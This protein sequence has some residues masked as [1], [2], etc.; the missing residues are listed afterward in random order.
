MN[1]LYICT[2]FLLVSA[3]AVVSPPTGGPVDTEPPVLLKVIP[4]HNSVNVQQSIF[5]FTFNEFFTLKKPERYI[6]IS[7]LLPDNK[8]EHRIQG[9]SLFLK[10]AQPLSHPTTYFFILDSLIADF[11]EGNILSTFRYVISSSSTIDSLRL[12]GVIVSAKGDALPGGIFLYLFPAEN[13]TVLLT[14]QFC[15]VTKKGQQGEF[16]FDHIPPGQYFLMA[17]Q[18]IDGNHLYSRLDEMVGFLKDPVNVR[19]HQINDTTWTRETR[20]NEPLR[21][22]RVPD[23]ALYVRKIDKVRKGLF[24]IAFSL[25]VD[26]VSISFAEPSNVQA[27]I[28][29]L[30]DR[31]DTC[32][33]WIRQ[34]KTSPLKFVI[35]ANGKTLDT[36]T[37]VPKSSERLGGTTETYQQLK[38]N[39]FGVINDSFVDYTK[40]LVLI[41]NNPI[42]S[43]EPDSIF[44]ISDNDTLPVT[45][46]LS[47]QNPTFI[48][49]DYGLKP[50]K[51]YTIHLQPGALTDFFSQKNDSAVIRFRTTY[52]SYYGKAI[53]HLRDT[54]DGCFCIEVVLK[55]DVLYVQCFERFQ[56]EITFHDLI[57]GVYNFR[58][59]S[60]NNCNGRWDTGNFRKRIEPERYWKDL[61]KV[62]IKS[63]WETHT[64]WFIREK[65]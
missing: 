60:D 51:I 44:I 57:P 8:I 33:V 3:C 38:I 7:P 15:Y 62:L 53:L 23:T 59:F 56:S 6:L 45:Y 18:D 25:P 11:R 47:K 36:I 2:I 10:F 26:T 52:D 46:Q 35:W 13:D 43:I 34:P 50:E 4:P 54:L 5:R 31:R 55:T 41:A 49:L 20:L 1:Y 42:Q 19:Y 39:V 48:M 28:S 24:S 14:P 65:H 32:F 64:D 40:N 21:M 58:I 27:Y 16:L 9:K 17:L 30:N 12:S 37:Y 61:T 29:L 22:F 63:N